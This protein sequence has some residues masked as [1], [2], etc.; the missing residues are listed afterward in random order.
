MK[1][2]YVLY[3][4]NCG[5]C[6]RAVRRLITEPSYL[7][8]RFAPA[9]SPFAVERFSALLDGAQP[10]EVFVIADT[11][12][13]YRGGSAWIMVLYALRRYRPLAMHL[14]RPTW[15][16]LAER[17]IE[18]I[19]RYRAG[20]SGFLGL[21]PDAQVLRAVHQSVA[22]NRAACPDGA[23]DRPLNEITPLD[24]LIQ[25]RQRIRAEW[26]RPANSAS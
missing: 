9:T 8:L 5:L 6:C 21:T 3:D 25:T 7:D 10:N 14:A 11:G 23:C 26:P 16:P 22:A 24:R 17:A 2:L 4:G 15:R 19:G 12:E 20:I 1:T 13:V 18:F